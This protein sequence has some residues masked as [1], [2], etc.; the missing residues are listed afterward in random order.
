MTDVQH[1]TLAALIAPAV[2]ATSSPGY[3]DAYALRRASST[4]TGVAVARLRDRLVA[5]RTAGDAGTRPFRILSLGCGD[6]DLDV[7]LL[8]A[9]AAHGPVAHVGVD[10]NV[11]SLDRFRS[12]LDAARSEAIDPLAAHVAVMLREGDLEEV[13]SSERYDAILLSHV[14]YYVPDPAALVARLRRDVLGTDGRLLVVHSAY[15]GVPA[16][17]AE[18][19]LPPFLTAEDIGT[20]LDRAGVPHVTETVVTELDAT[21]VLADSPAGRTLLGFLA[22][23]DAASLAPDE[24]DRLVAAISARCTVRDGRAFMPEP[25]SILEVRCDLVATAAAG[26]GS[27]TGASHRADARAAAVDPVS[28][29]RLLAEGFDWPARLRTG[30]RGA[31]GRRAVLDV[32]CGTGRWL[33]ALAAAWP[34]LLDDRT[35]RTYTAVDPAAGAVE[36][37]MDAA[38]LLFTPAATHRVA[39]EQLADDEG[40]GYDLVWAV[41]SLYAVALPDLDAVL[42]S[43]RTLLRPDG[44]AVVVLSDAHSFYLRAGELALGRRLFV[45]AEDVTA[46][47]TR[48]GTVHQVAHLDY[49]ERIP[50]SDDLALRR[51]L[52]DES[53]G[54]SYAPAG[55]ASGGGLPPQ[56]DEAWWWAHR[57]G[58]VFHFPQH[59]Q[60]I[61]FRR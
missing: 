37:A 26:T 44:V 38:R 60:V 50:A 42:A 22:E 49:A 46:A 16:V 61:T 54:N 8:R 5:A 33:R 1:P 51:Y 18:A 6:G 31:D 36:A 20:E 25:L 28:D 34:E 2:L 27:G 23:R 7:P 14:L 48:S 19:G 15:D 40:G 45:G 21:E 29:Y 9:L 32:G 47:L 3:H 10:R 58:G 52:W 24:L 30:P 59:V 12:R 17:M 4:M 57:H 53:I 43:L 55:G 13:A 56:P 39:V 11:H 41:H 35:E